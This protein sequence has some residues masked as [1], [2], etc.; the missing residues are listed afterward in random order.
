MLL[1]QR[2]QIPRLIRPRKAASPKSNTMRSCDLITSESPLSTF[3]FHT[4]L[5]YILLTILKWLNAHH[6]VRHHANSQ[7]GSGV[8]GGTPSAVQ[9]RKKSTGENYS[10][11][12]AGSAPAPVIELALS[13]E[14]IENAQKV[15]QHDNMLALLLWCIDSDP[16]ARMPEGLGWPTDDKVPDQYAANSAKQ[17]PVAPTHPVASDNDSNKRLKMNSGIA[18][19]VQRAPRTPSRSYDPPIDTWDPGFASGSK[20][21]AGSCPL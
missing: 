8:S 17:L 1:A 15:D 10:V 6:T 19:P 5:D 2:R 9:R 11:K 16:R 14:V 7:F 4:A 21:I 20:P 3:R 13:D 18:I 12:I